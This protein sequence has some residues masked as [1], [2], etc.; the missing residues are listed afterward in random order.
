MLYSYPGKVEID[1]KGAGIELV[2]HVPGA[3]DG[4]GTVG[5]VPHANL[6]DCS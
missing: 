2:G 1:P 5:D 3:Q 6:L 4:L